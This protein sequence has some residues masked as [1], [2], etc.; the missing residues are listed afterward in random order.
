MAKKKEEDCIEWKSDGSC[1]KYKFTEE[2]GMV[3]DVRACKLKEKEKI[4][5]ELK[6]GFKVIEK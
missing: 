3:A 5:K 6:R 1:A 2:E 4:I